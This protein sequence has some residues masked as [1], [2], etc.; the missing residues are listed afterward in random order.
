MEGLKNLSLGEQTFSPTES[1]PPAAL[2]T[3]EQAL[4]KGLNG[5]RKPSDLQEK[6]YC[7]LMGFEPTPH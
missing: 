7:A 4:L 3:L 1:F 2:V 5:E 6:T